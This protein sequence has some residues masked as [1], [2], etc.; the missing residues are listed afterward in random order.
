VRNVVR[1]PAFGGTQLAGPYSSSIILILEAPKKMIRSRQASSSTMTH[2]DSNIHNSD[3]SGCIRCF[4]GP[5]IDDG[6]GDKMA[7][8]EMEQ[9]CSC[10]APSTIYILEID[11]SIPTGTAS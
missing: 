8:I 4:G 7:M 1:N 10:S 5:I 11:S 2:S 6:E 9:L 3:C